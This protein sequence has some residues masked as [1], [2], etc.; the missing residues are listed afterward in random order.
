M[1]VFLNEYADVRKASTVTGGNSGHSS[2]VGVPAIPISSTY[3]C[4]VQTWGPAWVAD[5]GSYGSTAGQ[6][7]FYFHTDGSLAIE[8]TVDSAQYAG[9]GLAHTS[10]AGSPEAHTGGNNH[11]MLQISP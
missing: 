3:Y 4:W 1:V 5:A 8:S 10:P 11:L 9:F 7:G 6:R 2:F